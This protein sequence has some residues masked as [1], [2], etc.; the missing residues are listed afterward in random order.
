MT[1]FTRRWFLHTAAAATLA[2][3]AV[4]AQKTPATDRITM[5][6]IGCGGQGRGDMGGF[7]S[8]PDVQKVA[9]CDVVPEH[10]EQAK[11]QVDDR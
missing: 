7:M 3:P 2:A 11:K 4:R 6:T 5:A 8:F 1:P 9:V 10:R